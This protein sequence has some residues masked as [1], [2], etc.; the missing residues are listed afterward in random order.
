MWP[1]KAGPLKVFLPLKGLYPPFRNRISRTYV[2]NGKELEWNSEVIVESNQGTWSQNVRA[3]AFKTRIQKVLGSI[4]GRDIGYS[5]FTVLVPSNLRSKFCESVS[6]RP[7][8]LPSKSFPIHRSSVI[9]PF[10][11][12]QFTHWQ[13]SKITQNRTICLHV[14]LPF[15]SYVYLLADFPAQKGAKMATPSGAIALWRVTSM[16]LL[17]R[18]FSFLTCFE[19]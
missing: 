12:I 18:L 14:H 8:P 17:P 19:F 6:I 13:Q 7:R 2:T 16:G 9:L 3:V 1:V 4:P 10:D 5:E 15:A 11:C